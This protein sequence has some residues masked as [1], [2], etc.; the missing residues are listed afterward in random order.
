MSF[1]PHK[2]CL[3][4]GYPVDNARGNRCPECGQPFDPDDATT[5]ARNVG[6]LVKL[7][8][9]EN[10]LDVH[11]LKDMLADEGIPSTIMGTLL[12][13]A[14][15]ELPMTADTLPSL[16]VGE[17]D[18]E[19]ALQVTAEFDRIR[20]QGPGLVA[21]AKAWTCPQC[22]EKIEGQFSSCWNCGAERM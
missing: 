9:S 10:V 12:Q 2:F 6:S 5:F 15:G 19:R 21:Q 7:Y 18:A 20:K 16:W 13:S 22:G 4:C 17:H 3:A 1:R 8:V 11:L 14:R